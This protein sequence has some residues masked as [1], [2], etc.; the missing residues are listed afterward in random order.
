MSDPSP[1]LWEVWHAR[2]ESEGGRGYKYRPVIIVGV[3]S[4]GS[5][6]MMVTSS[7]NRLRL[8]HDYLLVDWEQAGLVKPS[9]A[10]VDRIVELP[11]NYI[12][13]AGKIGE[14][15][16]RDVRALLSILAEL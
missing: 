16:D 5:L 9:I 4:D 14:L 13:T 15:S 1:N 11:P 7:T 10:R 2:C 3:S 6:A 8:P 12:G